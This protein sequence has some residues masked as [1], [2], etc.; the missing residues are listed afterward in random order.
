MR[1][2]RNQTPD[3]EC[4][5]P[6]K[7]HPTAKLVVRKQHRLAWPQARQHARLAIG[8]VSSAGG[9]VLLAS[10]V[11]QLAMT[12]AGALPWVP[13]VANAA[14]IF[15]GAMFLRAHRQDSAKRSA[16]RALE[17]DGADDRVRPDRQS[18]PE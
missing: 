13:L 2:T 15:G 12:S 17:P 5:E 4:M 9:I 8:V 16:G 7:D 1:A 10:N 6:M 18:S 11:L 14:L 3:V